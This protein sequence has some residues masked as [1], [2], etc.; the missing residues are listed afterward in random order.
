MMQLLRSNRP[1]LD[2]SM[3]RLMAPR[4]GSSQVAMPRGHVSSS[5]SDEETLA[6][7]MHQRTAARGQAS[8]GLDAQQDG[9]TEG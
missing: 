7:R 1:A 6:Q 9:G 5:S 2:P 3:R 4:L 8:T